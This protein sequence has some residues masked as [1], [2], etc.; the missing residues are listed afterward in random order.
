MT[1]SAIPLIT[2][3]ILNQM[4][5]N[6]ALVV[7][8]I[9][10]FK[11]G[12]FSSL[13]AA[14]RSYKAPYTTAVNRVNGVPERRVSQPNG[15]KLTTLEEQTLEQWILAMVARGLPVGLQAIRSMANLL[16]GKRTGTEEVGGVKALSVRDKWAYNYVKRNPTI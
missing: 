6:E 4:S 12:Q 3:P 10:A 1:P 5:Q 7:L 8:A 11:R 9:Q 15:R 14:C 2:Q 16:L 13:Y